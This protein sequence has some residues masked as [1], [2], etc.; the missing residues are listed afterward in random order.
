MTTKACMILTAALL[1][2]WVSLALATDP[3]GVLTEI[4]GQVEVK[5]AGEAQWT[6]AQPLLALRPGDQLRATGDARAALVFTGGRGAQAVSAGNSPFTIQPPATAAASDKVKGL[7]GSVTDFLSGKQKDLAYLP[8]S[9]RSVRPPKVVQIQPRATKLLGTP[10]VFEWSGSN[11]LRYKLRLLGPHG[12]IWEQENLPR[13]P[14]TYP[15]SAPA[16]EPGVNYTWQLEPTGQPMQQTEFQILPP[17]DVAR[18][19]E[20]LDLLS[21]A[22]LSGYSASSVAMV[23]AG[24]EM[25]DGLYAD[26]RR[27]L[28][29]AL[30]SDPDEPTLHLL[31]GQ[32][33]DS[34]G[35]GEL[36]EREFIEARDLSR[37]GSGGR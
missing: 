34:I 11:T 26:A 10:V 33:Y 17:A 37:S 29:T 19:R 8:L 28:M 9:V 24:Y 25:R 7:V 1:L 13:K 27:E 35:L 21:P 31:L 14:F 20:S 3:V 5:R 22:S 36:A 30:A 2:A 18:V 6:A 23:R 16:L 12:Q 32:V 15:S 4:R